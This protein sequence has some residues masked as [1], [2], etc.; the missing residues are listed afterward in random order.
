MDIGVVVPQGW[1]GEF[2]G[3]EAGAAWART[4][5]VA[6]QAER[7][8]FESIWIFD[9]FQTVPV[10]TDEL[11]FE[12]FTSLSALAALTQRVR[13]G[14]VVICTAFR[15]PALTAKMIGTLDVISGGRMVL[16]VGAGWKED[17]FVAY[18]YPYPPTASDS[19]S[20]P[21]ISRSSPGCL[22]PAARPSTARY[23]ARRGRDQPAPWPPAAARPDHGRW[24]RTERHLATRRA[25]CGRTQSGQPD[26]GRGRR[27][28]AGRAAR[29]ARRSARP[30]QPADLAQHLPGAHRGRRPVAGGSAGRVSRTRPVTGS[31]RCS[32]PRRPATRRSSHWRPTRGPPD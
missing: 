19:G 20:S 5:Q 22:V 23:A 3:W 14:H 8:G 12:S 13:I 18:G 6:Q 30:G 7:L 15:N 29:G 9:H 25:P 31:R 2:D 4:V 32:R 26:P 1:T 24:Q 27:G 28:P 10:P 16:G 17:E 11:T 21:T